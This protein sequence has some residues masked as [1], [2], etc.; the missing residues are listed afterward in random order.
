MPDFRK[1]IPLS[2]DS[3]PGLAWGGSPGRC[4]AALDVP[5][6]GFSHFLSFPPQGFYSWFFNTITMK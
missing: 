5:A 4:L 3:R 2:T 1:D 6:L